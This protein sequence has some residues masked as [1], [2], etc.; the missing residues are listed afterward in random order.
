MK[1]KKN[2]IFA[3][4]CIAIVVLAFVLTIVTKDKPPKLALNGTELD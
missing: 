2:L 3:A 1:Q 4:A